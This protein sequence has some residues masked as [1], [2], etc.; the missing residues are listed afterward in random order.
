M[1]TRPLKRPIAAKG[2]QQHRSEH[3]DAAA[4]TNASHSSDSSDVEYGRRPIKMAKDAA[5]RKKNSY[6]ARKVIEKLR[7]EG[8]NTG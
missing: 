8:E 5:P 7:G 6:W 3:D 4:T 2:G 1:A